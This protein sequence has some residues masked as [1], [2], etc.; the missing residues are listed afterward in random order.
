MYMQ[1]DDIKIS[2]HPRKNSDVTIIGGIPLWN[3]EC[4]DCDWIPIKL[5]I[6]RKILTLLI[7]GEKLS[8]NLEV[9]TYTHSWFGVS[10]M[11][12]TLHHL[13]LNIAETLKTV[14]MVIQKKKSCRAKISILRP[15]L[16]AFYK[17]GGE[18]PVD[19]ELKIERDVIEECYHSGCELPMNREL[20]G[21][22]KEISLI[23]DLEKSLGYKIPR[24]KELSL[25]L[26]SYDTVRIVLN[27]DDLTKKFKDFF[28]NPPPSDSTHLVALLCAINGWLLLAPALYSFDSLPRGKAAEVYPLTSLLPA[29]L[30]A[31]QELV[32]LGQKD[33]EI[34]TQIKKVVKE[35]KELR[36]YCNLTASDSNRYRQQVFTIALVHRAFRGA[37]EAFGHPSLL[38]THPQDVFRQYLYGQRTEKI[39]A[40]F[41][42][43]AK[44]FPDLYQSVWDVRVRLY[45]GHPGAAAKEFHLIP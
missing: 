35:D 22:E 40:F 37:W 15:V 3:F 13:A 31:C 2:W 43:L 14:A 20:R 6:P 12:F 36:G 10:A 11:P 45:L 4:Q 17:S 9:P 32:F 23:E 19:R 29:A 33:K 24:R 41:S 27:R 8:E 34:Q 7:R 25:P 26:I 30:F 18:F 42:T 44:K 1:Y 16:K 38:E 21:I 39:K 28:I 5:R